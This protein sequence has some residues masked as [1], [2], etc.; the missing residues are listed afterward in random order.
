MAAPKHPYD[1]CRDRDC[2]RP[3]CVAYK[4]G[5]RDGYEDGFPDGVNACPLAHS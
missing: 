1:R 3:A 2:R 4:D 5:Y